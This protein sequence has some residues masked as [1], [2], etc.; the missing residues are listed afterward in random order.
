MMRS[1]FTAISGLKAHQTKMD[2]IGNNIANVN[3]VGFKSSRVTF[4]EFFSQNLSGAT[5]ASDVTGRGGTNPMQI[6]LGTNVSSID[7]NMSTGASQST[8]NAMDLMI[9]GDGFFI[10]GDN[11][12]TYFTRAGAFGLDASGNLVN[13]SGL[14]V[15]GWD[16]IQDPENPGEYKTIKEGVKPVSISG[17]KTYVEPTTTKN[18]ELTGNLNALTN[19]EHTTSMSFYDSLGNSYTV[20]IQLTYNETDE[21]WDI[22]MADQAYVNGDREKPLRVS[23]TAGTPATLT[24]EETQYTDPT[25]NATYAGSDR[26]Q[27]YISVGNAI[28]FD[29][30][31]KVDLENSTA[32]GGVESDFFNITIDANDNLP[33]DATF[34]GSQSKPSDK[35]QTDPNSVSIDFG[36]LTGFNEKES[37]SA[38][39]LDGNSAGTLANMSIGQDG[40]V[41]G[42]Y[43]NGQTRPIAMIPIANFANPGGLEKVGS[44]LFV[45]TANSGEFDGVGIEVGVTGGNMMGGTLEMSNVDLSTEFTEMITTQ[46]G[47]QANSRTITTSDEILQELVNLKR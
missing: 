1:M 22:N 11:S 4:S 18:I 28:K 6:G 8:G 37:A 40:T 41:Y 32:S 34:G 47:F 21:A 17:D 20:D 16:V 26:A 5:G 38:T 19:P 3:T 27:A 33:V 25:N 12:G 13:S 36:D 44:S 30:D 23:V 35:N 15:M 31:G 14:N 24:F 29:A 9:N 7:V 10:V 42:L 2:V 45:A 46:R 39:S 43:T